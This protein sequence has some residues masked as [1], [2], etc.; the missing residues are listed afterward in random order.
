MKRF[1]FSSIEG[2]LSD[3]GDMLM[4]NEAGIAEL[5]EETRPP[6]MVRRIVHCRGAVCPSR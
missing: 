6:Y 2:P 3:A 5:G 4:W 1:Y